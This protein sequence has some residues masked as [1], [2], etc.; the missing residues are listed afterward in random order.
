VEVNLKD[1]QAALQTY[2]QAQKAMDFKTIQAMTAVTT[3]SKKQLVETY[4]KYNLWCVYLER[5]ANLKFGPGEGIKVLAH[6]RSLDDQLALDLKR[7][8]EANIDYSVDRDKATLYLRV[9]RNRPEGVDNLIDRFVYLDKYVFI[10]EGADWKLDYLKTYRCDEPDK[11]QQYQFEGGVFPKMVKA[12]KEMSEDIKAGKY[13]DADAAHYALES[14]WK[15]AYGD[16]KGDE[17]SAED[18]PADEQPA[19]DKPADEKSGEDKPAGS[20]PAEEK[21]AED[22]PAGDAPAGDKPAA[23]N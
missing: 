1:P 3:A 2:L 16:N 8:R 18:K 4:I 23:G 14:K 20:K 7:V 12:M 19:G 11:E 22:K 13:R 5:Q 15:E 6:V 17:K 21:P 10:K 9:E